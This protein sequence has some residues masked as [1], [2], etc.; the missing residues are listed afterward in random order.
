MGLLSPSA[1]RRAEILG[2]A[3]LLGYRV[4]GS[5]PEILEQARLKIEPGGV[6]LEVGKAARVPDSEVVAERLKL[7][8]SAVGVR[9]TEIVE[10]EPR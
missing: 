8:A 6:R 2:R 7:L 9:G 5:V 4:S 3:M 10:A 1:R